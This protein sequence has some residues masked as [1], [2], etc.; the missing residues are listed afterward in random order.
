M[1]ILV[2]EADFYLLFRELLRNN[3]RETDICNKDRDLLILYLKKH[4]IQ[5]YRN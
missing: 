3:F 2:D 1:F 5:I 4:R